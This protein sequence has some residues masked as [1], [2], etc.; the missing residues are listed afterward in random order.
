MI[1]ALSEQQLLAPLV[2]A[3]TCNT[4]L[5][6]AYVEH[7][8]VPVLSPG[9]VVIYDN[10]RFPQSA[11]ARQLIE[12]A[13]CSQKFLPPYSPDLNPSEH[14]WFPLQ[15]RVRKLLPSCNRDLHKAFAAVLSHPQIS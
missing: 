6:E 2:F 12:Q 3:G 7:C 9:Q 5:F 10:A 13:G 15:N 1:A 11:K 14:A 4:A 8:L